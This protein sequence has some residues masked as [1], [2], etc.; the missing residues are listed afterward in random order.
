MLPAVLSV[1]PTVHAAQAVEAMSGMYCAA[2]SV[3]CDKVVMHICRT[4]IMLCTV[5]LAFP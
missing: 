3:A 1:H 4:D 2:V 5:H